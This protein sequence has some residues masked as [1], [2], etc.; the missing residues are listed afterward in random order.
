MAKYE[1]T[2]KKGVKEKFFLK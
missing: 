1:L 2:F